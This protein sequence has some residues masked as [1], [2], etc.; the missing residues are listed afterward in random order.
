M[1]HNGISR[2]CL[3]ATIFVP[4][5]PPPPP[6]PRRHDRDEASFGPSSLL[7]LPEAPI[8]TL[9]NNKTKAFRLVPMLYTSP[10]YPSGVRPTTVYREEQEQLS[11]TL[12]R[13]LP[14][15]PPS[16][17]NFPEPAQSLNRS[18]PEGVSSSLNLADLLL[19]SAAL[20]RVSSPSASR[21][22]GG[23]PPA[24][25]RADSGGLDLTM[26]HG[27]FIPAAV[28]TEIA[29]TPQSTGKRC[30][31]VQVLKPQPAV[32]DGC[33]RSPSIS[34]GSAARMFRLASVVPTSTG[35]S[36]PSSPA[37]DGSTAVQQL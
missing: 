15:A 26:G 31:V 19:T 34:G 5:G 10:R 28:E 32:N 7:N 37:T 17:R 11:Q 24:S 2:K 3:G 13:T 22:R 29:A 9:F 16:P 4:A 14:D 36:A 8:Y 12:I 20:S 23:S 27:V 18:G 6:S 30:L 21:S 35:E 25:G 1:P 33:A